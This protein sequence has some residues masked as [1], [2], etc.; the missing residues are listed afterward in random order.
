MTDNRLFPYKFNDSF[1]YYELRITHYVLALLHQ[2]P[3]F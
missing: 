3:Y 2:N 1:C